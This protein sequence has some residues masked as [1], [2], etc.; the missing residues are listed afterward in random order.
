MKGQ[1]PRHGMVDPRGLIAPILV[2]Q[3][4]SCAPAEPADVQKLRRSLVAGTLDPGDPAVVGIGGQRTGCSQ[5]LDLHCTGTLIAPRVVLTAAHCVLRS[6]L[7]SSLEI[8]IG[9]ANDSPAASVVRV[10]QAKVHPEYRDSG[11]PADLAVLLLESAVD[12]STAVP[13]LLDTSDRAGL[14]AGKKVRLVGFG[15]T[16]PR[17]EPP[18]RKRMGTAVVTMVQDDVFGIAPSPAMSCQG[19]S[20]GPVFAEDAGQEFLVGVSSYGDPGCIEYGINVRVDRFAREFIAPWIAVAAQTPEEPPRAATAGE[21]AALCVA[22]CTQ[23]S[24]CPAG[25]VCMQSPSP[26]GLA[27]RCTVPGLLAGNLGA[28]CERD[29]QCEERCVRLLSSRGAGA[30]RCY[31]E[32]DPS[33]AS[34]CAIVRPKQSNTGNTLRSLLAALGFLLVFSTAFFRQEI[35]MVLRGIPR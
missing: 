28:E 23:A 15:T 4:C 22:P 31:R 21:A 1:K 29:D 3:L 34:G 6:P 10:S 13:A 25:M 2:A 9:G 5:L 35:R 16:G 33:A 14:L 18:G 24:T 12:P 7:G 19:D 27:A 32:C 11:D 30:C 20:G 26:D 17:S 8:L